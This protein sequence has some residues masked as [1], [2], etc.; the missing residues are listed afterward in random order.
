MDAHQMGQV[1]M[2]SLALPKKIVSDR[3]VRQVITYGHAKEMSL[4]DVE[5]KV[6]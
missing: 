4:V 3:F 5:R 1:L 2:E 6:Y